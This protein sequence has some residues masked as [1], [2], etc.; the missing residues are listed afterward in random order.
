MSLLRI[1][2]MNRLNADWSDDTILIKHSRN[3]IEKNFPDP[4]CAFRGEV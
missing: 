1:F 3:L 2:G 4:K